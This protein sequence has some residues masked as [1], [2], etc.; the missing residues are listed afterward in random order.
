MNIF[1][2]LTVPFL[3]CLS[4]FDIKS[5]SL[6]LPP[7]I[8]FSAGML[9]T[10]LILND[11][12][13]IKVCEAFLFAALFFLL[14]KLT[15]ESL[16]GGDC[17]AML[18]CALAAGIKLELSALILAFLI[19]AVPASFLLIARKASRKDTLPFIPFLLAGHLIILLTIQP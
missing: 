9:L 3:A 12:P 10:H 17:L 1:L 5:K 19:S 8:I 15:H 16:G 18:S 7:L 4:Y 11:M 2:L 14:S 6:P 13:F